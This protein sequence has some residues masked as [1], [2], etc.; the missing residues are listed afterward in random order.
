MTNNASNATHGH[1][2]LR[3]SK[4]DSIDSHNTCQSSA[5]APTTTPATAAPGLICGAEAEVV[6]AVPVEELG[7]VVLWELEDP[8]SNNKHK[9]YEE[10]VTFQP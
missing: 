9:T 8:K 4:P 1:S 10:T 5:S 7:R 3:I 6:A 2:V